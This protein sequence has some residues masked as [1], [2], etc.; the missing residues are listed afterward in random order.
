[1]AKEER[2]ALLQDLLVCSLTE[3]SDIKATLREKLE[4]K[5]RK[6][7]GLPHPQ[8]QQTVDQVLTVR[9]AIDFLLKRI[10]E[11]EESDTD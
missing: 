8:A 10:V 2:K 6:I 1:M 4:A 3:A 5:A 11:R 9:S 7:Y